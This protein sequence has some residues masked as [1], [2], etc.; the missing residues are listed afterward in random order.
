LKKLLY[1]LVA[2]L[3][4]LIGA[5]FVA[6]SFIDWNRY[7]PGIVSAVESA[8]GR[9]LAI[10]GPIDL[11]LLRPVLETPGVRFYGLQ[12]GP[13]RYEAVERGVA[14]RIRGLG[15]ALR[16]FDET[17]S[18][19]AS[20]DLVIAVDTAVAHLAGAMGRPV[21]TLLSFAPDWRWLLDREDSP[22]YPTM[23][24]FRQTTPGDWPPVVA[25]VADA[26]AAEVA[27]R[28]DPATVAQVETHG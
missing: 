13:R 9:T 24:L 14:D 6:P 18:V 4:L 12:V 8:T 5:A 10:E 3:V 28:T 20:L 11:S 16:S 7:K 23:R 19:L 17:A 2:V 1:G 25:R 21:W 22:W 15:G 27:A 26:L